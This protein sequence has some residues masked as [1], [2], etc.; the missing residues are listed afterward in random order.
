MNNEILHTPDGVRDIYGEELKFRRGVENKILK[1][2]ENSGYEEIMTPSFE[3]FDVFS[4]DIGTMPSREF[5]KMVDRNGDTLV[6]R[7]DFTPS[8]AR[9]A[10]RYFLNNK[11][12]ELP[13]RF[14]YCGNT[15]NTTRPLMGKPSEVTQTG[16]ELIGAGDAA[17]DAEIVSLLV[18]CLMDAGLEK[19]TVSLGNAS[20][21]KGLCNEAGLSEE[22]EL[23]LRDLISGR[24]W[25]AAEDLLSD[26]KVPKVVQKQLLNVI[27]LSG[28]TEILGKA[29]ENAGNSFSAE[30][31]NRL[32]E[33]Y[34]LIDGD[35][36]RH[37]VSF[38]LGLLSRY[39]Y[40]TGIIFRAYT[41][42]VGDAIAMGGRYDRLLG[43]FGKDCPA[44]GFAIVLDDVI[45]ALRKR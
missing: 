45:A 23:S 29:S 33:T 14:Y 39:N 24:N 28:N 25:F 20:Y 26:L 40:Y 21:F 41:Y 4:R 22:D 18:R 31:V 15:F 32:K 34:E 3:Y 13:L 10:A 19:F 6:F 1:A 43:K 44:T 30:A 16:V 12:T 7:P 5:Y 11:D 27:D 42:G 37:F 17:S 9:C 35:E 38:D 8:V 2:M 36:L